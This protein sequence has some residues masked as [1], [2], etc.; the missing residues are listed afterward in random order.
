MCELATIITATSLAITAATAITTPIAAAGQAKQQAAY[1]QQLANRQYEQQMEARRSAQRSAQLQNYQLNLRQSQEQEATSQK[2]QR[3]RIEALEAQSKA[4][5][6][7]GEAG[8]SGLSVDNLYNDFFR[9]QALSDDAAL[10]NLS[11]TTQQ[12][13]IEKERVRA[14]AMNQINSVQG[15]IPTP[16]NGPS[17]LGS[18]LSGLGS[19]AGSVNT[20]YTNSLQ[21]KFYSDRLSTR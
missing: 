13:G 20:A 8:V 14:G 10:Q 5:V 6:S 16:I 12:I 11:Y 3:N 19:V 4:R 17:I 9:Q 1:Q 18:T 7:A 21:N 2:L 15:Y